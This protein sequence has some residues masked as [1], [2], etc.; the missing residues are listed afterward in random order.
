[1]LMHVSVRFQKLLFLNFK[2]DDT[3]LLGW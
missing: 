2:T 3:F 1:M